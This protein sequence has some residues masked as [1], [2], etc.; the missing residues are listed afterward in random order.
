MAENG[1][2]RAKQLPSSA[3]TEAQIAQWKTYAE[4]RGWR[5]ER[6]DSG[7]LVPVS[8]LKIANCVD[9]RPDEDGL[10][11]SNPGPKIQG[12]AYGVAA[13]VLRDGSAEGLRT[14]VSRIQSIGFTAGVHSGH[15]G[16]LD[17]GF[18]RLWSEGKLPGLPELQVAPEEAAR[19]VQ[20]A[21]ALLLP[22]VG[23]HVEKVV[24]INTI[25]GHTMNPDGTAFNLDLWLAELFDTDPTSILENAMNTVEG[26]NGPRIA[27]VIY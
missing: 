22:L 3:F 6:R 14:T 27:E 25:P 19:I 11:T 21:G 16:I 9:G 5:V 26:L 2:D 1:S 23:D 7:L 10:L 17:C 18:F 13:V 24:R 4:S 20:E 12:G 15:H 8:G